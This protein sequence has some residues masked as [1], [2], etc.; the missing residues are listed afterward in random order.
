MLILFLKTIIVFKNVLYCC[1]T[2]HRS[3]ACIE[4]FL[5]ETKLYKELLKIYEP[6]IICGWVTVD[7]NKKVRH[8]Q[9]KIITKSQQNDGNH[10]RQCGIP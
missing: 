2:G 6:Q 4:M 7:T 9:G 3:D 5:N 10:K 1:R 8:W